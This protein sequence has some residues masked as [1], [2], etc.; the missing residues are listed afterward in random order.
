MH[1]QKALSRPSS[2]TRTILALAWPA[3]AT[4]VTTPLLSLVDVAVVGHIGNSVYIG[5]IAVGA[6]MFN[7]LYWLM[8]FLRMG[9]SGM[10]AQAYGAG[11]SAECVRTLARAMLIALLAGT[12]MIALSPS[13]GTH[14]LNFIDAD[15]A[16]REPARQYFSVAILGAPGLL[17]TY[18]LSGW[19]LGMQTSRPILWMALVANTLNIILNLAFV[20]GLGWDVRGVGAATAISQWVSAA[21][22]ILLLSRRLRR[23]TATGWRHGLL[24]MRALRHFFAINTDIFLRTLCLVAVTVWF[25]HAGATMGVDTLSANAIIMQLFILFSYLMDGFAF[26]GEALAGKF[27]GA[28]DTA[29]LHRLVRVL[30]RIGL[31]AAALVTVIYYLCGEGIMRL[32]TN[33]QSVLRTAADYRLWAVAVPFAGFMSFLWDGIYVGLTRTRGMLL[34]MAAAMCVFY[35]TWFTLSR[36]LGNHALWLAFILYLLT[37]G[38]IQSLLFRLHPPH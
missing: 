24:Q 26:A 38:L 17:M 27:H 34:S 15:S 20:Y 2:L 28:R 5:A 3:V 8:G 13:L 4:N 37:R 23:I 35:I 14:I 19:F 31:A 16:A 22:G 11:D 6:V 21:T 30:M 10:T 33:Q 1:G 9:T 32:L 7:M 25:T 12:L 29:G 36:A 18:A